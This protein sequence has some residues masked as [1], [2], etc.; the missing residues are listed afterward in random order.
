MCTKPQI[1]PNNVKE[2]HF[3]R[4]HRISTHIR[5]GRNCGPRSIIVKLSA[6][7]ELHKVVIKN[8]QKG[9]NIGISDDF[10]TEVD[11]MSKK[12][13]PVLKP[14]KGQKKEAYFKVERPVLLCGGARESILSISKTNCSL[15][16]LT[17]GKELLKIAF[18][19]SFPLL[20]R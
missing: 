19:L 4:V 9:T 13:Q 12:L 16:I 8:L 2:I 11:E 3:D 18:P 15:N 20:S 14:A 5:D 6:Q 1:P 7:Q 10:P 17:E